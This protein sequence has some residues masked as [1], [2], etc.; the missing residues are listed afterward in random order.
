[1]KGN[2]PKNKDKGGIHSVLILAALLLLLVALTLFSPHIAQWTGIDLTPF[3]SHPY[4]NFGNVPITPAFLIK[5]FVFLLLIIFA[6]HFSRRFIRHQ[7]LE[8]TSLD[9]GQKYALERGIGYVVFVIGAMI[10]LQ[11]MGLNLSSLV[12]LGGAIG[13]GIGLGLQTIANNFTSGIIL[14]IERSIKVG[15][16]VE[17]GSLNGDVAHIGPRA[18]WVRTNDNIVVVIP[19]SHFTEKPVINWTAEDRQIRFSIPVG[20]S[21]S[22]DPAQV[23]EILLGVA[24][25]HPDVL[26]VPKPSVIFKEFGDSSL[27]FELRVWT[28]RQV[29][30]PHIL[31]SDLYFNIFEAFRKNGIE[32]PFPQRD[33]HLKSAAYLDPRHK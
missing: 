17:V 32:I 4:F 31:K 10:G 20:V 3:W 13:I 12:V 26:P 2:D 8:R 18:T 24:A 7:I 16:R 23:R 11:S 19:N 14:L 29:Q 6:V 1:M 9:V 25:S 21:Y 22:S 28:I 5:A 33:L 30:T 27:N 15:D